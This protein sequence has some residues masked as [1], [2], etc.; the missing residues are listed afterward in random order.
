[1]FTSI[2][3]AIVLANVLVAPQFC[4]GIRSAQPDAG[5]T[6]KVWLDENAL[7]HDRAKDIEDKAFIEE[8]KAGQT[9]TVAAKIA[10]AK[11]AAAKAAHAAI[12]SGHVRAG[13]KQLCGKESANW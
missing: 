7:D 4:E 13:Q 10:A 1:M 2:A 8:V 11:R 3:T 12:S 6:Y 9:Q 5:M